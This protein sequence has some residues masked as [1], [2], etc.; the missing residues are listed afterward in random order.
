M[1]VEKG[2]GKKLRQMLEEYKNKIL[3][4][5]PAIKEQFGNNLQIDLTTPPTQTKGNNT[6]EAAYFR[7]VPTVAALTMLSKFQNDVK[8]TE[9]R[10]VSYCHEQVGKVTVRFDTYT[11]IVGQSTNY[12][13]PGQEV[14][15]MAGVGAFSKAAQPQITINGQGASL[16]EDGAARVKFAAGS[17]GNHRIPVH[18]VYV[19]QEGKQQVIDKTVEYTV[20]QANA[21]IAPDKTLVSVII[22]SPVAEWHVHFFP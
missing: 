14:E 15:I 2:E 18:I 22:F 17:I 5:D 20:G 12:A 4:I 6:W 7:M 16:G 19:D 3:A 8:T 1:M 21:S 11:A 9:N 10:I 13:M